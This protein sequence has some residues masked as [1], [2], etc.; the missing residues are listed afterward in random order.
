[1]KISETMSHDS[2]LV[3]KRLGASLLLCKNLYDIIHI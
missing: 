1:M 2:G 3:S